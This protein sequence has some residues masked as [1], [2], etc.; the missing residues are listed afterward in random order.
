MAVPTWNVYVNDVEL[1]NVQAVSMSNGRTKVTDPFRSGT[2]TI[3]GRVPDDLPPINIGDTVAIFWW[4][5]GYG[6]NE[7]MRVADLQI[8]Y[9]IIPSMDTWTLTCEDAMA[10]LG[11]AT[12]STSW[13]AGTNCFTNAYNVGLM[14]GVT[15]ID[16]P[17]VAPITADAQTITDT[18]ALDIC[19]TLAQTEQALMV[20]HADT[21][22]WRGRGWQTYLSPL[23]ITDNG[24]G[25]LPIAYDQL[26]FT[27]LADNYTE[28][29]YV[30]I[31]NGATVQYGS[32]NYSITVETYSLSEAQANNLAAYIKGQLGNTE[33][34]P[35]SLSFLVNAQ[36]NYGWQDVE[37]GRQVVITFRGS[38][39]SAVILGFQI[40]GDTSSTRISLNLASAAFFSFLT[41]NS[42]TFG[43]LDYNKLGW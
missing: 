17:P 16:S 42:P 2:A 7:V 28:E 35:Y 24:T 22:E 43:T 23:N 10:I 31:R 25:T 30:A 5:D 29:V 38:T 37:V 15:F 6:N 32:G 11:R 39:Y 33:A 21:I 12:V 19:S 13:S 9:G 41:L 20:A 34:V 14:V 3:S 18:N 8:N 27:G 4:F 26:N 1:P 36:T 40:T